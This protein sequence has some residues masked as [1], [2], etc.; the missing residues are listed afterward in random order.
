MALFLTAGAVVWVAI[1]IAAPLALAH[2][3]TLLPA[4][5]YEAGGL[6]CHQRPER[7]FHLAGVQ[8]PVCAR[9]FGLYA[10]G[11]VGAVAA[12]VGGMPSSRAGEDRYAALVLALAAAPTAITLAVE[13][14]GLLHPGGAARAVAAIPLGVAAGWLFV[15]ALRANQEARSCTPDARTARPTSQL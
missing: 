4:V 14:I 6:I 7:S 10:S 15:R 12:A 2:G 3:Y 8:L 1:I 11:A 9:C 13:W 5:I